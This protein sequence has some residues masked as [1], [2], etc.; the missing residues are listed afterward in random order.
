M[1]TLAKATL[2]VLTQIFDDEEERA[3]AKKDDCP[4]VHHPA[5]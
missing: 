4:G 3:V 2:Y 5:V 1:N